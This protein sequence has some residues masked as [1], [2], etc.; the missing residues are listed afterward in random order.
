MKAKFKVGSVYLIEFWDHVSGRTEP[1]K[2]QVVG[3]VEKDTENYVALTWWMPEDDDEE[4]VKSNKE[5]FSI[6][7]STMYRK[8]KL[9]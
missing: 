5:P 6:I 2:C 9:F 8:R 7:K 3:W 1:L 4:W